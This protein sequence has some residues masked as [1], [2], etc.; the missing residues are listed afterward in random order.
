MIKNFE[1][2]DFGPIK[3]IKS[4]NLSHLNLVIGANSTGKTFLL[5]A[6][7]SVIRSH[8]ETHKGK[9]NTDFKEA[10][11]DKLYWTFQT[12]KIG[13]LVQ[14]K[15]SRL[16]FALTLTDNTY[17]TFSFGNDTSKQIVSLD[18]NLSIRTSNSV[19]L[20]PKEVLTISDI[21]YQAH[22][23]KLF[24]FDATYSDL[25]LALQEP[26]KKGK[27]PEAFSNA[28]RTLEKM[29]EGKVEFDRASN[30]WHYKKGNK[31]FSIN[32]TAEG[33]KKIAI[34]DT[35]LGNRFLDKDSIVFIDE[36]ESNLHPVALTQF[37]DILVTLSQ[38][39]LQLFISSHSYFV[40]KYLAFMAQSNDI[41]MPIFIAETDG[42]W[43][44]ENLQA[45]MPDNEIINE[46][47]RLYEQEL[48]LWNQHS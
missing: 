31:K 26:T 48:G 17:L 43:R 42:T 44:Q 12:E 19:F 28:R 11:R 13:D 14:H 6:L 45:G 10:L 21:I 18:N 24:G 5:K 39:G 37:L 22:R 9:N 38:A 25:I 3:S 34:L 47:L 7:Y 23:D 2:E 32:A 35:L 40:I 4:N 41:S 16:S 46:S 33:I 15:Q 1:L 8:E 27:T 29:F 20:P 36:P 30:Q